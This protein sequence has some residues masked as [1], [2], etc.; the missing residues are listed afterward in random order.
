V[1]HRAGCSQVA[2]G[3]RGGAEDVCEAAALTL[4]HCV[5]PHT[6]H[7]CFFA[8]LTAPNAAA[9]G[10]APSEAGRFSLA[11]RPR[12]Q[13]ITS[14]PNQRSPRRRLPEQTEASNPVLSTRFFE[15]LSSGETRMGAAD[16]GFCQIALVAALKVL[17]S[18][19]GCVIAVALSVCHRECRYPS[20]LRLAP[21]RLAPLQ[22]SI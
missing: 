14:R 20:W 5:K 4:A 21:L 19:Q 22:M 1:E 9:L 15:M 11:P 17:V 16:C 18:A 2:A 6:D 7:P 13:R 8:Q 12:R 3:A 10:Q